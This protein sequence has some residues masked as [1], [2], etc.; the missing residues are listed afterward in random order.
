MTATTPGGGAT[1]SPPA[2]PG[3]AGAGAAGEA[4]AAGDAAAGSAGAAAGGP[5]PT[6]AVALLRRHWLVSVL[7][8]AGLALRVAALAAYHPALIYVDSLKYL[9]GASPGSEPLGYTALLRA[10]LLAGD[11]G[12]VA[13][14]QH[15]A[16]LAMGATVYAVLLRRGA[17]RWL[18]AAAAAPVLLDAYQVQMEQMIMPDVWFEVM[19]VAGL[20]VMLWRP[21]VT[22]PFA[23]AA[24]LLLGASATM[25]QLGVVLVLPAVLYLLIA[26]AGSR[27]S[28]AAAAALAAAFALPVLGYCTVSYARTGHFWLAHRQS[29]TGRLVAAADC[30]T[31]K[32]PA[33]ARP[34]CPTPAE[35]RLGPDYLE[36]SGH[37]RLYTGVVPAGVKR[38][39]LI[40]QLDSAV[41]SQQPL[42]VA[43]AITRDALRLFALTRS[44]TAGVTPISR[45]QFQTRY[46]VF[47]KWVTLGPGQVIVVGVQ[48][49]AFG[50]FR[51]SVLK[52]AYG[53]PARVD[54]PVAAFLRSYQ[55]GGGYTPGPL[56]ALFALAGLAGSLL[57]LT[58]RGGASRQL[59]LACLLFTAT[60]A[61]VLLPPDVYEF[62][63]RYQLTAVVTLV[64][65]GVLGLAALARRWQE[66]R[67]PAS[68][69]GPAG[70]A[71]PPVSPG[72]PAPAA[73]G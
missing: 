7:L 60:A 5:W 19:I 49:K 40:S 42:R 33:V 32:I 3:T 63:W 61:A 55:L 66:R 59:A 25:K 4:A 39:P 37:S 24:G 47:P 28:L 35:Q 72:T 31:L 65:A 26:G 16:G 50:P 27:R 12:T 43:G 70:S 18:A 41:A 13:V 1:A 44:D 29:F 73:A 6:R 46:P 57:V 38:G 22:V 11:L 48:H 58:G 2:Q 67:T 34:L 69:A 56:L 53:G 51:F 45:W 17:G 30:A 10:V 23:V 62:S 8:A 15:L 54:R 64:P 9:Y 71:D 52:P 14:V 20:A 36:H 68:P 21:A